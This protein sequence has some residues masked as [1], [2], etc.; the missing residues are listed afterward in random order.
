MEGNKMDYQS[1]IVTLISNNANIQ[2]IKDLLNQYHPYDLSRAILELDNDLIKNLFNHI[3]YDFAAQ[4]FEYLNEN[5]FKDLYKLFDTDLLAKIISEMDLDLSVDFIRN[6]KS[7][8]ID[9]LNLIP[10]NKRER[11]IEVLKYAPNEIGSYLNDSFLYI[12]ISY[13]VKEAMKYVTSHAHNFDYIS[14]VYISLNQKLAGYIKLKNLI[15]ARADES[16]KDIM[17]SRFP[18]VYLDDDVEYVAKLMNETRESSIPIIDEDGHMLGVVTHDDLMDIVAL[19]EEED[20]TKFAGLSDFESGLDS[21]SV[22]K[23]VRT[24]LPWLSILLLLSMFTSIILSFFDGH[25]SNNGPLLAAKL[26]VFLPL[27]L[28]M[29]GNTGTQSLA[30]TIRYL[31]KNEDIEKKV[32]KRMIF[33]EMKTGILQGI[34]IGVVVFAMIILTNYTGTGQLV[35][36]DYIFALTT[37]GA[38]FIALLISTT[39]GSVIPMIM[40][41][42]RID[43]AVASG[44]FIT[45]ISDIITLSIYYT[46]GLSILLPMF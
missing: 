24:R 38:I 25:L 6:L 32:L 41:R 9:I 42:F 14:I 28:D 5:E 12:D 30:V 34:L 31:S 33:R 37:S 35:R 46:I 40:N 3:S 1:E 10:L 23:S 2:D 20:Y 4:I 16:I 11:I 7:E 26:A 21:S 44:P 18:K 29:A 43:P 45:T 17:E 19:E 36:L 22:F 13:S 15:T 39:L 8:S 27:I